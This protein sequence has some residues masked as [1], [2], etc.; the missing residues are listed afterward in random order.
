MKTRLVRPL[1]ILSTLIL[2]GTAGLLMVST[3]AYL[4]LA[5]RLP[6]AENYRDVR[7]E[8]PLRI[9]TSDGLLID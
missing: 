8:T 2:V 3:A 4:Y 9:Y 7:L 1:T 5:P 6:A